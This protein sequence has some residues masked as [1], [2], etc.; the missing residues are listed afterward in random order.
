MK[1][2]NLT[3]N[4]SGYPDKLKSIPTPPEQLFYLGADP[5]DWLDRPK[6]AVVGS[7]GVTPYGK[8]VT[9]TL[10]RELTERGVVIY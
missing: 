3:L 9:A 1:V 7:R 5:T 4:A 2:K 10:S 8:Q 6:V